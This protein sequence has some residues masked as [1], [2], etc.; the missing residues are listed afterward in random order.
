MIEP[1]PDQRV[2]RQPV[3]IANKSK[4][5]RF[6]NSPVVF[7]R[8]ER[9]EHD[10][11]PLLLRLSHMDISTGRGTSDRYHS[12]G[13]PTCPSRRA[14]S[15]KSSSLS[16]IWS[17]ALRRLDEWLLVHSS[18]LHQ[19]LVSFQSRAVLTSLPRSA[20]QAGSRSVSDSSDAVHCAGGPHF[21][22]QHARTLEK[23]QKA[24]KG[25]FVLIIL[26]SHLCALGKCFSL[27]S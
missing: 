22:T 2:V 16:R 11:R 19:P 7:E 3:I 26:P 8:F 15:P 10:C 18:R 24:S 17:A 6:C 21:R 12:P 14:Q 9:L 20:C 5:S 1:R 25:P 4:T 23:I 27:P 13:I